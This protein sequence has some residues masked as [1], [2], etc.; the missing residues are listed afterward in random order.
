[1]RFSTKPHLLLDAV[2]LKLNVTYDAE[3]AD[4]LGFSGPVICQARN[5][6]RLSDDLL[7]A[8]H[9]HTGWSFCRLRALNNSQTAQTGE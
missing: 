7:L 8:L 5:G 4:V 9:E 1:M 3:L 2:K 6:R